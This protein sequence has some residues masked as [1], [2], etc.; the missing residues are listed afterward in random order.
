MDQLTQRFFEALLRTQF[1]PPDRMLRYQHDLIER[2]VLHARAQVPFYRN[3]GRLDILFGPDG[4]IDWERWNEIP[5]LTR[6]D[7]QANCEQLY[8][9]TLPPD[10][11]KIVGGQT[12]G[13]TGIPLVFR[14][15]TLMAAAGSAV[16]ERGL[17]WAGMPEI[18]TLAWFLSLREGEGQYPLGTVYR[19]HIR[20]TER[21]IHQLSVRTPLEQQGQWLARLRPAIVMGYPGML[22]ELARNLPRELDKHA[23]QLVVCIG[24]VASEATRA[25]IEQGFRC[26]T[27]DVY[28]GSEF[29]IVAVED[30]AIRRLLVSEETILVEFKP[31]TEI[32]TSDGRLAELIVTPFYNYAMPLIR[33]STGDLAVVDDAPAPDERT[34]RRLVRIVGRTRDLFILPSGRR[35]WPQVISMKSVAEYL[36]V[37]QVQYAQTARG[38]IELRF[39]SQ[40]AQPVRNAPE[41]LAKLRAAVPEPVEFSLRQMPA[42]ARHPSGKYIDYVCEIER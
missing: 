37:V 35:W 34:Q 11:G 6:S 31:Q 3:G 22:A 10:C 15:N 7:A 25:A 28:S 33:Y 13:S 36:D 27:M 18:P 32:A 42:I 24:E 1:L 12:S 20:G 30:R 39:V 5:I 23:F 29:G 21:E 16:L 19:T 4:R 9:E 17:V 8:A 40:A 14:V 2:L 41:L 26:P 38:H